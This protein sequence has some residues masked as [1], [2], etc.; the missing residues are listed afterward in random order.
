LLFDIDG[1][2]LSCSGRGVIAMHRA[3]QQ[4]WGLAAVAAR[5]EPQGKTDPMLFD[6][7]AL[8][9]G[10]APGEVEARGDELRATYVAALDADLQV[11]GA[12]AV[13][14]GVPELLR[15]LR[16]RPHTTLGLVSGNLER[17]AWLKLR[18]AGIAEHFAAGAFGSDARRRADLVAL[19]LQRLP[20]P[21]GSWFTAADAWVIGDTPDDIAG[22]RAHGLRTLAVATGS[23]DRAALAACTPDVLLDDLTDTDRI[24]D[25]LCR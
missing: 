24:V 14:P 20:A 4:I 6:E 17:T 13:K 1:T 16:A 10:L 2:L 12:C 22:A 19:A 9:Y 18:A 5:I 3:V 7:M 23:F 21:D 8:A 11:P 25:T 15:A